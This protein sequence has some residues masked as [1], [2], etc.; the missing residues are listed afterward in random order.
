MKI[1]RQARRRS[2]RWKPPWAG[3]IWAVIIPGQL[4]A[5]RI[6]PSAQQAERA[7]EHIVSDSRPHT[8]EPGQ[9]L[10]ATEIDPE[11]VPLRRVEDHEATSYEILQS[12]DW[13]SIAS[14]PEAPTGSTDGLS[15]FVARILNQLSLSAWL[16]AAFLAASL[17]LLLQFRADKSANPLKA[18]GAL[19]AD[20]VRVLVLIIPVLVL[21]TVVTQAFSFEAIRTLEG[22]W[23]RRGVASLART[24]MIKRHVRRVSALVNRRKRASE[25]AYYSAEPKILRANVPPSL[26]NAMKAQ[27]LEL[28]DPPPLTDEERSELGK[29]NWE[30]WCD[31]WHIAKIEHLR[32]A[33]DDYPLETHRILPTKLGNL[34]RAT[35][36]QLRNTDGE[37]QGFALRRYADAPRFIQDQHDKF[38]SR[39]E[40]YCTLVFVSASLLILTPPILLFRSAVGIPATIFITVCF[41]ALSEASYLAAIASARGY[42]SSLREI[43]NSIS[44]S[45]AG[46]LCWGHQRAALRALWLAHGPLTAAANCTYPHTW[47]S[48]PSAGQPDV[49]HYVIVIP[50]QRI[51]KP[52]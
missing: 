31:A 48:R 15:A 42:C 22:Y 17:A 10:V 45:P 49:S 29:H 2:R 19:T 35:E 41:G 14:S 36:D 21:T 52:S 38:R 16:P 7:L 27:A 44:S 9:L 1:R 40:M 4:T 46:S 12:M 32:D 23:R 50:C 26:V 30:N 8:R 28:E 51:V 37:V 11:F 39:L 24:L 33:Q 18:V 13:P 3:T 25:V 6:T 5:T 47:P 34:I 20:P 43:D